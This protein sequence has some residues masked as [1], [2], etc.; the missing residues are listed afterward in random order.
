MTSAE[1]ITIG[2]EILIGQI[3]DTN[4]AWLAQ[5][6]GELGIRVTRMESIADT[7]DQIHA[8]LRAALSRVPVVLTTGGLGPTSDDRT[9]HVLLQLFGGRMEAHLPTLEH[10]R[11]M[12]AQRGQPLT[13]SNRSQA[14][15]PSSCRVL[16]NASG[17]APGMLFER[18]GTI[19]IALP[20]V[21]FEM[22]HIMETSGLEALAQHVRADAY[23]IRHEVVHTYG[24]AESHLSDSL[25]T[26]E[27]QLPPHIGL[28][29]LPSPSGIRLR[30]SGSSPELENLE[31][32]LHHLADE[33]QRRVGPYAFGRGDTTL[34]REVARLLDAQGCTLCTAESC[35]GGRVATLLT[36]QPGASAHFVGGVVAYSNAL[37]RSLLGVEASALDEHGAVS[38]EVVQQ[39]ALGARRAMGAHYAVATSGIAGPGGGN[40]AKPVGLVYIAVASDK[41][42][43]VDRLQFG[44]LR[45]VNI[46]RAAHSALNTL[47]L[48]L[49]ENE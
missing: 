49:L 42:V 36:A 25:R 45:D 2:D 28:A 39:M 23:Y 29:Y 30:L 43:V 26:F 40:P 27:Q 4:S 5:R 33:L 12:F 18:Q 22:R 34:P 6:L 47:R 38:P 46:E 19:L 24:I 15:V 10:V 13:E 17:T 31:Q 48:M 9:K 41:Q 11:T 32:Q 3:V 1:I 37:K 20:G 21:P 7:P 35:T 16:P 14:D 44:N 8:A